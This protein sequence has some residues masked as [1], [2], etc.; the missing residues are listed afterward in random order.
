MAETSDW[1]AKTIAESR[2]NEGRVG[3]V[4]RIVHVVDE[5]GTRGA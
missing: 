4:A 3:G 5:V 2:T 1:N